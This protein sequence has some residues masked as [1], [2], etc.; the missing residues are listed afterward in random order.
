MPSEFFPGHDLGEC[1]PILLE[2]RMLKCR[3]ETD[4]L[5]ERFHYAIRLK[6]GVYETCQAISIDSHYQQVG[7]FSG[8]LRLGG[9][10]CISIT[11]PRLP[12]EILVK[13]SCGVFSQQLI[14]LIP[15]TDGRSHSSL[16]ESSSLNP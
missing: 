1:F 7:C 11:F 4:N 5:L 3:A 13:P 14:A 16:R 15:Q 9:D 8:V 2:I 6:I 12:M 10:N